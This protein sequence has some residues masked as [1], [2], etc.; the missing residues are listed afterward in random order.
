MSVLPLP[1]MQCTRAGVVGVV[2]GKRNY[3]TSFLSNTKLQ[4][5]GYRNP[6]SN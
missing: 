1:I 5:N 3:S 6:E 2:V 4:K